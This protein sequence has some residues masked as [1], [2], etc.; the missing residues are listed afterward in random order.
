MAAFGD[1]GFTLRRSPL[2]RAGL[3]QTVYVSTDPAHSN[4][5]QVW[6]FETPAEAETYR[7][8][9]EEPDFADATG[10][11]VR[12]TE[13]ARNVLLLVTTAAGTSEQE[14]LSDAMEALK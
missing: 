10:V 12:A 7:E 9:L 14:L 3:E 1:H 13:T 8:L 5:F 4:H 2:S 11:N 6:L